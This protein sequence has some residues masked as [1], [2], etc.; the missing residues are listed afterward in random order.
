[1]A[2]LQGFPLASYFLLCLTQL[3][4]LTLGAWVLRQ[5]NSRAP[6]S[7]IPGLPWLGVRRFSCAERH[8]G[9]CFTK[10]ALQYQE[11]LLLARY[12]ESYCTD[13]R[14]GKFLQI[15]SDPDAVAVAGGEQRVSIVVYVAERRAR[16]PFAPQAVV[17]AHCDLLGF[18]EPEWERVWFSEKA[19]AHFDFASVWTLAKTIIY[20]RARSVYI[21]EGVTKWVPPGESGF[22]SESYLLVQWPGQC[23]QV[24]PALERGPQAAKGGDPPELSS[25]LKKEAPAA[26]KRPKGPSIAGFVGVR[27]ARGQ[28]KPAAAPKPGDPG[29]DGLFGDA[30]DEC[31]G[32]GCV[33]E[34]EE[35]VGPE[36]DQRPPMPPPPEP[37]G[38]APA[39]AAGAP[40]GPPPPP[41]PPPVAGGYE[42]LRVP[43]GS[44][45]FSSTLQVLNAHCDRHGGGGGK[46][47]MDRR[48]VLAHGRR[49][50]VAGWLMAWLQH[51]AVTKPGHDDAKKELGKAAHFAER[52][53][54]RA[55][56][57]GIAACDD[58]NGR[59]AKQ[60]LEADGG[61]LPEPPIAV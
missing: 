40:P 22:L 32:G 13:G 56:L 39:G 24:W 14:R 27:G 5:D 54:G 58:A 25:L 30:G 52:E 1:M 8:P 19:R 48:L 20:A 21:T 23:R 43:G 26:A 42:V 28:R 33:T 35:A 57:I 3:A 47:K 12:I 10:D 7:W 46:C 44:L 4:V 61:D 60:I 11:I 6:A 49:R 34:D 50:R 9:V 55:I 31:G 36:L 15:W 38:A 29:A 2:T 18:L 53:A 59:L 51:G 16:R 17:F 41:P 45:H 37:P